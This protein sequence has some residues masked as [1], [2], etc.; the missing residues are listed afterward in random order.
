MYCFLSECSNCGAFFGDRIKCQNKFNYVYRVNSEKL[1]S[2]TDVDSQI[3]D[4]PE[5]KQR[6]GLGL[7]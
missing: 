4:R 1:E 7:D 5:K 2:Q 6:Q 3:L